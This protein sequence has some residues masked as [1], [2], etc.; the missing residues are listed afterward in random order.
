MM[1]TG[2]AAGVRF[3]AAPPARGGR[4]LVLVWHLL[5]EPGTP[6]AMAEA[7]PLAGLDAWRLYAALP[8]WGEGPDPVADGYVPVVESAVAAVPALV[9]A[10]RQELGCDDGPVDLVGGS[11]GG[12]VALTTAVREVVPVRR[13]AVVN[14]AVR[15]EAV[16]EAS[17]AVGALESYTWTDASRAAAEPLDVLARAAHLDLPLLVVRGEDE[18]PAFRPVQARLCA[19]APDARLVDV[20]G[21]AH[22]LVTAQ[23]VVDSEVTAWLG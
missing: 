8:P 4:R 2:E 16:V 1:I 14:P 6:E 13:V 12:H 3:V 22:M 7:L 5:G 15:V 9:T 17:I 18:Y 10:A 21:L 20:P 11:A 19:A 23:D